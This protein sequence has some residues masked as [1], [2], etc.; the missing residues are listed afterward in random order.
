MSIKIIKKKKRTDIQIWSAAIML[1]FGIG[2]TIA[3]FIVP[4]VGIISDSVLWVLAQ[5]LIYAGSALGINIYMQCKFNDI[6]TELQ[7][8][9]SG[10]SSKL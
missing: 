3:G 4:P 1:I 10:K 8:K 9:A 7:N 5:S 2:L 6:K